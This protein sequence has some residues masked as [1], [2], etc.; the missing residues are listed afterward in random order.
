MMKRTIPKI[1]LALMAALFLMAASASLRAAEVHLLKPRMAPGYIVG[2][3]VFA[4]NGDIWILETPDQPASEGVRGMPLV[5]A[6][7]NAAGELTEFREGITGTVAKRGRHMLI[8]APDDSI[9]FSEEDKI[10]HLSL[11]GKITE[12]PI[13][14]AALGGIRDIA[15]DAS[16]HIWF[17]SYKAI[18]KMAR[19]GVVTVYRVEGEKPIELIDIALETDGSVWFTNVINRVGKI[20]LDGVVTEY[21]KGISFGGLGDITP[22][23]ERRMWFVAA[24][25]DHIDEIDQ[26][27]CVTEHYTGGDIIGIAVAPNGAIWFSDSGGHHLGRATAAG[28]VNELYFEPEN[29]L[30]EDGEKIDF[31]VNEFLSE[32][33]IFSPD[34]KL[35]FLDRQRTTLGRVENLPGLGE[36]IHLELKI[37]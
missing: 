22:G 13:D 14:Q 17:N 27:G 11:Q 37:Y 28:K 26:Q 31:D 4:K 30:G 32:K 19:D 21:A 9:W 24:D 2:D 18:G 36:S 5:L 16:G 20:D 8:V 6:K 10:G 33:L 12:F 3:F 29:F 1:S 23:P 15:M 34:G 35:W 7:V 25:G